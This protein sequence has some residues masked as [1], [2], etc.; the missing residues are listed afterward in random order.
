MKMKMSKTMFVLAALF[1]VQSGTVHAGTINGSLWIFPND[2][3]PDNAIPA[4][5]PVTTPDVT[6][7]VTGTGLNLQSGPLYTIGEF[8]ASQSATILTG[9]ANLGHTLDD[10]LFNFIGTVSVTHGMTFTAGHD[11]GLTLIIG[12]VTVIS[13][14][15]ATSFVNTTQTYSGPTGN[16]PFQLV[17]GECCGAPADLEVSLPFQSVP[18][19]SA[20]LLFA[21]GI[22]GLCG[23]G[24]RRRQWQAA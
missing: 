22:A 7:S 18:E 9:S 23:Y 8:L 16:E 2:T 24:W 1:L 5:V 19:P 11:D 4:N 13:A 21:T 15:G 3:V 14:P 10:T 17:Y 6:F 20:W 12:G